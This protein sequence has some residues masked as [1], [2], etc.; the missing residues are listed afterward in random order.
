MPIRP[1]NRDRYPPDWPE[2]SRRVREEAGQRCEACAAPNGELI[3]RGRDASGGAL[4][5]PAS[6]TAYEDGFCAETGV[7]VPDTGADTVDWGNPVK[8]VL[9]VAHLDHRPENVDRANLRAWCQRC[10][11]AYDAPIRR[12]GISQRRRAAAA[13]GDLIGQ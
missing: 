4:W 1:E 9:T 7:E 13:V 5:R 3:R 8:V 2:I 11:N 6:A 10:H 12:A